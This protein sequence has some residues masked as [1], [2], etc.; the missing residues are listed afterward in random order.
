VR[1]GI[2]GVVILLSFYFT[3]HAIY[4]GQGVRR[5]QTLAKEV[6]AT[7]A[8]LQKLQADRQALEKRTNGLRPESIDPDMLEEQARKQLGFGKDGEQVVLTPK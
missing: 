4:G 7:A 8:Q 2:V 1:T 5:E 6:T 3:Y